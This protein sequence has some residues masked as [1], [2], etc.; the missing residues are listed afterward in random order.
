MLFSVVASLV[1]LRLLTRRLGR[2]ESA[3]LA[4][5]DSNFSQLPPVEPLRTYERGDEIERLSTLFAQLAALIRTQVQELRRTDEMRRDMLTSVSHDLRTP[6][7]TMRAQLEAMSVRDSTLSA[8]QRREYLEASIKQ[9]QRL[10]RMVDQLLQSASLEAHQVRPEME[11][12]Q[13]GDLLQDV[14]QKLEVAAHERNVSLRG[15]TPTAYRSSSPM[16]GSLSA[17]SIT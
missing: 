11:P 8:D 3:M 13:L 9:T 17:S 10:T 15:Q 4:F 5:R 1:V 14:I 2:L 12:M 16:Q 7:A 6:L